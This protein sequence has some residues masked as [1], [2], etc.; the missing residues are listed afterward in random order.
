MTKNHTLTDTQ[1]HT[2]LDTKTHSRRYKVSSLPERFSSAVQPGLCGPLYRRDQT[3][4]P[5]AH[6]THR[7]DTSSGQDSA[8]HLNLKE[9]GHSFEDST[10][11]HSGQRRQMV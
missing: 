5:Q 2:H 7:K 6:E 1:T 3:T 9:K 10:H 8:V 11:S 4:T